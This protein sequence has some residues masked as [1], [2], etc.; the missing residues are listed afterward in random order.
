MIPSGTTAV[1]DKRP[2]HAISC[3]WY[4]ITSIHLAAFK[5]QI[6]MGPNLCRNS[7]SCLGVT[8]SL[9]AALAGFPRSKAYRRTIPTGVLAGMR[10][11]LSAKR[12]SMKVCGEKQ[13]QWPSG[14][15]RQRERDMC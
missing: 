13:Q 2:V 7:V 15:A 5:R 12:L 1:D 14:T 9:T 3:E 8:R 10:V 4:H 11:K 6:L